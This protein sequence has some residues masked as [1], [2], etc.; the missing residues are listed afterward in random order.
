MVR[1][2]PP[3][4]RAREEIEADDAS[5]SVGYRNLAVKTLLTKKQ[6]TS[7]LAVQSL[8]AEMK[9]S[10]TSALRY[11]HASAQLS[12][13]AQ[14]GSLQDILRYIWRLAPSNRIRPLHFLFWQAF[15]ETPLRMRVGTSMDPSAVIPHVS[16]IF[17]VQSA[18]AINMEVWSATSEA[19]EPLVLRGQ[20][21]PLMRASDSTAAESVASVV[22]ACPQI[23][24]LAKQLFQGLHYVVECDEAGSNMRALKLWKHVNPE[25]KV[26]ECVCLA[27]KAHAITEKTFALD[28]ESLTA[29]TRMLLTLVHG[30][31][32]LQF[33]RALESEI[34]TRCRRIVC[35]ETSEPLSPDALE[36]R[37]RALQLYLPSKQRCRQRAVVTTAV[38]FLNGDW[39]KGG[40]F[41]HRCSREGCCASDAA[42]VLKM[43][44]IVRRLLK[45]LK[46]GK[47]CRGNWLHWHRPIDLICLLTCMHDMFRIGYMTAFA[48]AALQDCTSKRQCLLK[49]VF[50]Y[51]VLGPSSSIPT[52]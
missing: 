40:V 16:K 34:E 21:A 36:T 11:M 51:L 50:P 47:L 52:R 6:T 38:G 15:D 1:W 23:P 28:R 37:R 4:K 42:C 41:E 18:W 12:W 49:Q 43:R 44:C 46:P 13:D 22:H 9:I 48:R 33:R 35:H 20:W 27:H 14:S 45:S 2:K 29:V 31:Q 5:A 8:C 26:L 32:L 10:M 25:P 39:S 30:R 24:A 3:S 7:R 17:V 19:W